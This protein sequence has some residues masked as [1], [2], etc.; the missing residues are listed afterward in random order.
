VRYVCFVVF[1]SFKKVCAICGRKNSLTLHH[2]LPQTKLYKRLYADFIH[3][4]DN[5]QVVC[6]DCHL[7][8]ARGLVVWSEKDFCS[9]FKI[10]P[11]GKIKY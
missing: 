6:I 3:H 4:E 9:H 2:K 10:A 1:M 5:L 8:K 7:S 11:R